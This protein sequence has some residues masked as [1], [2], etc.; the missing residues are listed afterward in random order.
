MN[1]GQVLRTLD[2]ATLGEPLEHISVYTTDDGGNLVPV[3][4]AKVV[5]QRDEITVHILVLE[6]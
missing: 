6:R 2:A 3:K 4:S 1:V 5:T